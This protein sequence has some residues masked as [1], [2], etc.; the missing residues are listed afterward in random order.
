MTVHS[1]P[2]DL[3]ADPVTVPCC[4]AT[5]EELPGSDTLCLHAGGPHVDCPGPPTTHGAA[6]TTTVH[7]PVDREPTEGLTTP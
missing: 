1:R 7:N 4:G 5:P 6:P 2:P 3:W